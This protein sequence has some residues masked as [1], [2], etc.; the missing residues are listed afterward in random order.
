MDMKDNM[1]AITSF[2]VAIDS[3]LW[4]LKMQTWLNCYLGLIIIKRQCWLFW[5]FPL[6]PMLGLASSWV[7]SQRACSML[8]SSLPLSLLASSPL[9]N[10]FHSRLRASSLRASSLLAFS[11][12]APS[13][14]SSRLVSGLWAWRLP[15]LRLA[16]L[17]PVPVP[18]LASHGPYSTN[19]SQ[20]SPRFLM[21]LSLPIT[22]P[23]FSVGLCSRA[24]Q[25]THC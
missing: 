24:R 20:Q 19:D 16:N 3:R 7:P 10:N 13:L 4:F 9:E 8:A 22:F 5:I 21:R 12:L 15:V 11:K 25:P 6:A 18:E 14:H 17:L 1:R 23:G 2:E